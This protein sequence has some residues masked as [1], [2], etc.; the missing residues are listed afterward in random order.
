MTGLY[1]G[2]NVDGG[3]FPADIWGEYMR[4]ATNGYCGA[5]PLPKH[6]FVSQPFFG[7]YSTTGADK[8]GYGSRGKDETPSTT[9]QQ[10]QDDTKPDNGGNGNGTDNT[11][12]TTFDPGAYESPPEGPPVTGND[13]GQR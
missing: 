13:N 3:T 6:A 11:G 12:G 2:S 1:F 10:P 7:T 5:F 4:H 9:D 8:L